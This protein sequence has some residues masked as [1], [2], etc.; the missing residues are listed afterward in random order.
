M[1]RMDVRIIGGGQN[2]ITIGSRIALGL[3]GYYSRLP[4]GSTVS[5]MTS[6]PG[7]MCLQSIHLVSEGAYHMGITTPGWF[8]RLAMEGRPPFDK[9]MPI[10]ALAQFPHNDRMAFAVRKE[11]GINTFA[12]LREQKYPLKVST[13]PPENWH[14]SVWAVEII[15]N[16]HGITFE[17]IEKWGGKLLRDRPRFIND[18]G[19]APASPGFDAIFDEALM[20]RRWTNMTEQHDTVFLPV[21]EE[22][23][24][25][26]ENE[27]GWVRGVIEKT[28]YRGMTEDVPT[29]DFSGWVLFC[30]EDMDEELA[31]LTIEAIDEQKHSIEALFPQPHAA[32]TGPVDMTTIGKT[33]PIPLHPGAERYYTEKGYH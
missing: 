24:Q 21:E 12:D 31:Y 27:R 6:D 15:L 19:I 2:W 8:A 30:H 16:E 25:K 13:V 14:P 22:V 3:D 9:P 20:T 33:V 17:D 4:K 7:M 1:E 18:P 11:C 28:R 10:R 26:L 29:V 23:M 5:V 32:L